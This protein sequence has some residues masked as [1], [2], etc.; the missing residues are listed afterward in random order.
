M[1]VEDDPV[2]LKALQDAIY[3]GKVERARAMTPEQ[4][5]SEAFECS[6]MSLQLMFAGAMNQF[7]FASSSDGWNEVA[8]RIDLG[9]RLHEEGRFKPLPPLAAS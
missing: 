3:R 6:N 1:P 8:R 7:N 5:L 4:R 9:R 2:A